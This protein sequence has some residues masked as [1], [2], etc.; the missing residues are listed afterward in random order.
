MRQILRPIGYMT[1]VLLGGVIQIF[2]TITV[3]LIGV[4]DASDT[5]VYLLSFLGVLI[6]GVVVF[7]TSLIANWRSSKSKSSSTTI[8]R[9]T[10][11][12]AVESR[13]NAIQQLRHKL[14]DTESE[15]GVIKRSFSEIESSIKELEQ[16]RDN[17]KQVNEKISSELVQEQQKVKLSQARIKDL[18]KER[19]SYKQASEKTKNELAQ[20]QQKV[21]SSQIR[22]KDLEKERDSF[23]QASEKTKNELAQEQQ[24][25][26]SSQIR[27]K[28]LEKERDSFKQASE[29]TKNELAQEQQKVKSSQACIKDL[30]KEYD[31]FKQA[32]EKTKSELAQEQQ[33][34]KSSQIRVKDLEKEREELSRVQ[35]KVKNELEQEKQKVISFQ[36]HVID[37]E[38]EIEDTQEIISADII[39]GGTA[40]LIS[41]KTW[42]DTGDSNEIEQWEGLFSK[43]KNPNKRSLQERPNGDGWVYP[44]SRSSDGRRVMYLREKKEITIIK[45]CEIF[46]THD[47]SKK[48]DEIRTE[49]MDVKR[50]IGLQFSYLPLQTAT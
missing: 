46:R 37:L 41:K 29:K 28:D 13:N 40:V 32:S 9:S 15:M 20:E 48:Y 38:R 6:V 1:L 21:K 11:S 50:Y 18:E 44:F 17:F 49:G 42:K 14:T 34:V 39:N 23:K 16:E 47:D 12:R 2:S 4:F 27:V 8:L 10:Y 43:I 26:K 25:V 30:E 7:E 33:K 19:D 36:K 35:D 45:I 5:T 3:K 31:S 22:V 24:K